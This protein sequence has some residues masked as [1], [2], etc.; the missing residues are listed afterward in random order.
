MKYFNLIAKSCCFFSFTSGS[1]LGHN[2]ERKYLLPFRFNFRK[3]SFTYLC[4]DS[5]D[6]SQD[7]EKALEVTNIYSQRISQRR[8]SKESQQLFSETDP[9]PSIIKRLQEEQEADSIRKAFL[10]ERSTVRGSDTSEVSQGKMFTYDFEGETLANGKRKKKFKGESG[11]ATPTETSHK[12]EP[13]KT[14]V[15]ETNNKDIDLE[16]DVFYDD[17]RQED[18][19]EEQQKLKEIDRKLVE[20][21]QR[22]EE[23]EEIRRQ[24]QA[25]KELEERLKNMEKGRLEKEK[26][27]RKKEL[28]ELENNRRL[29]EEL[30]K[31]NSERDKQ[32]EIEREKHKEE[33]QLLK[34]EQEKENVQRK[35]A[36]EGK[37]TVDDEKRRK[38]ELLIARM[39][40]IDRGEDPDEVSE[41]PPKNPVNNQPN[42]V[43]P[44]KKK[45]IFLASSNAETQKSDNENFL[46]HEPLDF[47]KPSKTHN[48]QNGDQN[49]S[50][51]LLHDPLDFSKPK[52]V[53]RTNTDNSVKSAKSS[54]RNSWEFKQTDENLHRGLPSQTGINDS[55]TLPRRNTKDSD[56]IKHNSAS[57]SGR[58]SRRQ[59]SGISSGD[60]KNREATL[61]DEDLKTEYT[62]SSLNNSP[63]PLTSKPV[64]KN[65]YNLAFA[66]FEDPFGLGK[67]KTNKP[68]PTNTL[69]FS[70]DE[71][72]LDSLGYQPSKPTV[73]KPMTYNQNNSV[74]LRTPGAIEDDDLEETILA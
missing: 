31:R 19:I 5:I 57:S 16:S 34:E 30:Q 55:P 53:P 39:K 8:G 65:N 2:T 35:L 45:P 29:E 12:N 40:A 9:V 41:P 25:E 15:S 49:S 44:R 69:V 50:N 73:K 11:K 28:E 10:T 4:Y 68:K 21:K 20:L 26:E 62:P 74:R 27:L 22:E 23:Q 70:S 52:A 42:Q 6:F 37:Q 32:I 64:K 60:K 71:D 18:I 56:I 47:S 36:N 54:R 43:K 1:F 48:N 61:I 46:N 17:A 63:G 51:F 13:I 24:K 3:C 58:H 59:A 66:E 72:E 7:R 38:K 33:I 14:L 67:P